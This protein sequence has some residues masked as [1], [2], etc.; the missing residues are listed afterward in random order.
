MR[1]HNNKVHCVL[2]EIYEV[3][4]VVRVEHYVA[5][6]EVT[7]EERVGLLRREILGKQ[8]EVGL[9]LQLMEV[10]LDGLRKQYLK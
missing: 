1:G 8:T 6:L 9:K 5:C 10:E 2:P 7:I 3:R 4:I